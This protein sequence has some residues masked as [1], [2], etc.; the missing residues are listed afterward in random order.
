MIALDELRAAAEKAFPRDALLPPRDPSWRQIAE[1]GWLLIELDEASGGLGLG[2]AASTAILFEQGRVLASAPLIPALLGLHAIA[3]SPA[4]AG[5]QGWIERICGGD[6]VPL[7]MLP[8]RVAETAQGA[9]SGTLGGVFEAD[10]ARH[11]VAGLAGMYLLIPLDAPGVTVTERPLWDESRRMFDIELS[12]FVPD[13]QLILASGDRARALH[14]RIS[15]AAQLA[16]AADALGGATALLDL[17]IEYLKLRRQFDRPLA[18]FQALKHRV[19]DCKVRIAAAEA[20]LWARAGQSQLSPLQAGALKALATQVYAAVAEEAVQLHG[21]IGLTQEHPCHRFLKRAF[22]N[23][24]LCGDAD[25][26]DEQA[27][28][29]ALTAASE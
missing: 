4:L 23:R 6:Y 1:L 25:Y 9:L 2:P 11:V 17:T 10:M 27:G 20:L 3:A 8:A 19:A 18:L 5:R 26:W 28:R 13:P 15:P 16:L 21:G 14:D 22:L 29:A 24:T 7:N 12:G